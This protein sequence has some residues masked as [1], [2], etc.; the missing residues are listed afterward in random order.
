M[1]YI[2]LISATTDINDTYKICVII[3]FYAKEGQYVISRMVMYGAYFVGKKNT[4]ISEYIYKYGK[5][6]PLQ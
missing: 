1:Q 6:E 5:Y 4:K 3:Q 2:Y